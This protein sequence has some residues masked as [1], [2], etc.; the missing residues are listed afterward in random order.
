FA[1]ER[2]C[3]TNQVIYPKGREHVVG[4]FKNEDVYPRSH[5]RELRSQQ[6]W[7]YHGRAVVA[8]SEPAKRVR[9]RAATVARRRAIEAR[10][11]DVERGLAPQAPDGVAGSEGPGSEELF[12]EWQTEWV[13]PGEIVNDVIPTNAFGNIELFHPRMLP[14]GAAHVHGTLAAKVAK[15][16]GMS[17]AKAVVGFEFNKGMSTP[18]FEGV[19]VLADQAEL[20]KE[21]IDEHGG[22]LAEKAAQAR[23]QRAVT[24]WARLVRKMLV[25]A[26]LVEQYGDREEN[27]G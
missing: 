8:G 13:T 17:F 1:L 23:S 19:V 12:G 6:A 15:Q 22:H 9:A 11:L 16:L 5:V 18:V 10:R 7:L 2:H 27:R 4:K 14:A 3:N 25:K 21:A 24:G 26:R 20:L